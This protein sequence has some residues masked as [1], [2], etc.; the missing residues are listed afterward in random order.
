MTSTT[1]DRIAFAVTLAQEYPQERGLAGIV[2]ELMRL[3]RRH[4]RLQERACNETVPEGHDAR[5]EAGIR[6]LCAQLPGCAP[7]FS[8]DPRGCTVKLRLP[9]GRTDDFG[10]TG[11]CVPQ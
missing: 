5:C 4:A 9:S 7:I 11:V 2:A 1:D 6:K 3:S 10:G 8:G